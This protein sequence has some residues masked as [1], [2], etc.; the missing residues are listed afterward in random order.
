MSGRKRGGFPAEAAGRVWPEMRV[1]PPLSAAPDTA[2]AWSG[3]VVGLAEGDVGTSTDSTA[4]PRLPSGS[5]GQ[6]DGS[7]PATHRT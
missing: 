4:G 1:F 6:S 2:E 7:G 5:R 3:A